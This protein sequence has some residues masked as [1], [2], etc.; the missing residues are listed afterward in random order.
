MEEQ[1]GGTA[2][3]NGSVLILNGDEVD[4][5]LSERMGEILDTVQSAYES[6]AGGSSSLPHS[7]FLRFP[8]SDRNRII[9]L[10]AYLGGDR[11]GAGVKWVSSFPDNLSKGLAR[12]SAV[13]VLNSTVTGAPEAIIEGSVIS[14]RRTAASA[15]LAAKY[16]HGHLETDRVGIVGCGL[17]S[18][19]ILRFLLAVFPGL[20]TASVYDLD[21]RQSEKFKERARRAF[22]GLDVRVAGDMPSLF[23]SASLVALA[24]TAIRPHITASTGIQPRS[25]I[26]HISLR[27]LAPEVILECDNVVDDI[28][29]VC[30]ADT[31]VHLAE[32]TVGNRDF[33]RCTL[34]DITL[35]KAAPRIDCSSPA[36]FSPFGLGIL[37]IAVARLAYD[38]AILQDRGLVLDSFAP[39]SS[40]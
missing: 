21:D 2:M 5:L 40:F 6:H 26:L 17:I 8:D 22:D 12:A 11:G 27:D 29:H 39:S 7:T 18:F 16:L 23:E 32:K 30:R 28:D 3:R 4:S 15:A 31:S 9:A 24:T 20:K 38:L 19:E 14:A 36:V 25:T 10:P 34:A 1:D 33:I 35:G 13:I 37:D